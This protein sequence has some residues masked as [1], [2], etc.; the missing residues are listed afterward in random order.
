MDTAEADKPR[1]QRRGTRCTINIANRNAHLYRYT[2]VS[3][4]ANLNSA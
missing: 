1:F 4:F 2:N 3:M